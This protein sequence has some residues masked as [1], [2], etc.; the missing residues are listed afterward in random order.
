MLNELRYCTDEKALV[1]VGDII[2]FPDQKMKYESMDIV[3]VEKI[4]L[5]DYCYTILLSDG[6]TIHHDGSEFWK[7]KLI[8]RKVK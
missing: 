4:E 3:G 2:E 8:A 1:L 5:G 7:A 6:I